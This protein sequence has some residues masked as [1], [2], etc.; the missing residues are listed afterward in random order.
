[1]Y[2]FYAMQDMNVSISY[3]EWFKDQT[4]GYDHISVQLCDGFSHLSFVDGGSK[5]IAKVVDQ[6]FDD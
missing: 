1:M 4:K 2:A 5:Y 6:I 3:G